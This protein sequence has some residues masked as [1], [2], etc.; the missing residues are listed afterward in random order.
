MFGARADPQAD[1]KKGAKSTPNS[2]KDKSK[3]GD[4]EDDEGDENGEE[5]DPYF[6]PIIP[7]PDAIEVRT[8]EEDEEKGM[9]IF[10]LMHFHT[11]VFFNAMYD[12]LSQGDSSIYT[13]DIHDGP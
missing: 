6:E 5:H 3:N 10:S 8:G 4:D 13:S 11:S 9:P 7:L 1:P 2:K 12:K